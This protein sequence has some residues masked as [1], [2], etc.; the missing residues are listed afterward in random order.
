MEDPQ[1][2]VR[3]V[4]GV[5]ESQGHHP[6]L[7]TEPDYPALDFSGCTGALL[8]LRCCRR[9]STGPLGLDSIET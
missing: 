3:A 2:A 5:Q 8:T 4:Q 9:S 6:H 7:R 1:R